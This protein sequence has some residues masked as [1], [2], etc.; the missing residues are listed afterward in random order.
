[1][2]KKGHPKN[3]EAI[4]VNLTS[5]STLDAFIDA[6]TKELLSG[7][8]MTEL[9]SEAEVT[10]LA[11]K[12]VLP[13]LPSLFPVMD[14][15][16]LA[17]H[18]LDDTQLDA[19]A[20]M[21]VVYNPDT[22]TYTREEVDTVEETNAIADN[23]K[24]IIESN[25]LTRTLSTHFNVLDV[26]NIGRVLFGDSEFGQ[27]WQNMLEAGRRR[28][29]PMKIAAHDFTQQA[30]DAL[31]GRTL[32][33]G[34]TSLE[35]V[36]RWTIDA[37]LNG[38]DTQVQI[39]PD[40]AMSIAGQYRTMMADYGHFDPEH[41]EKIAAGQ[42]PQMEV[43][44]V[45]LNDP[46]KQIVIRLNDAQLRDLSDMVFYQD[47]ATADLMDQFEQHTE[48]VFEPVSRMY[49]IMNSGQ[50]P[51]SNWYYPI[52]STAT[53]REL[54]QRKVQRFVDDASQL[55]ARQK[56]PKQI[57][58]YGFLSD[59]NRYHHDA[60]TYVQFAPLW[61]NIDKLLVRQEGNLVNMDMKKLADSLNKLRDAFATPDANRD[62]MKFSGWMAIDLGKLMQLATL[63]RFAFNIA[64]PIKQITGYFSAY[65]SGA[66][67]A[68]Y[69][70][71]ELPNYMKMIG[72]SYALVARGSRE[73]NYTGGSTSFDEGIA[74]LRSID[75]SA[76]QNMLWRVL[77]SGTPE[78][79]FD[80]FSSMKDVASGRAMIA[81]R[82]Q[83]FFEEYGLAATH[84]AD[85][86]VV[87]ALYNAA[88]R[89]V[90]ET[91]G[92][93]PYDEQQKMA[94]RMAKEALYYSNNTY[95]QTDRAGIQLNSNMFTQMLLLYKS[96]NMKI[97]NTLARRAIEYAQ[98]DKSDQN[99]V[100]EARRNLMG[101]M[102]LNAILAPVIT[103]LINYGVK[104]LRDLSKDDTNKNDKPEEVAWEVFF[105]TMAQV[106]Q[107]LPAELGE[108][109]TYIMSK[110]AN[111]DAPRELLDVSPFN[112]ISDF[113]AAGYDL[114]QA[115]VLNKYRNR[116]AF[117]KYRTRALQ[118]ALRA[119]ATV[120]GTPMEIVRQLNNLLG[121]WMTPKPKMTRFRMRRELTPAQRGYDFDLLK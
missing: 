34:M 76:A 53:E 113:I 69:L 3:R 22:D 14:E 74:E 117:E 6:R 12:A 26:A 97:Y 56:A 115:E 72:E 91:N 109:G 65:G 77:G 24:R 44:T 7:Q 94:A 102:A 30:Y 104:G 33:R 63:S 43:M 103:T 83:A 88:K 45:D 29:S 48:Q 120:T 100:A 121:N 17:A 13:P 54:N 4:A 23:I 81:G 89:Q 92:S 64:I 86:A 114:F 96:H 60:E 46:S 116:V 68:K 84:R 47:Q 16:T 93:L 41:K 57:R 18:Q 118:Q 105:S 62:A 52:S 71:Q 25:A 70:T 5:E 8:T 73:G 10:R 32:Y 108:I 98:A 21:D 112:V 58:A 79:Q 59:I 35:S 49:T 99:A 40:I 90:A 20:P 75:D 111:P 55:R 61:Q 119:T 11:K 9:A 27:K 38:T 107:V 106:A 36:D 1:M 67:D 2:G 85:V 37:E 50:L 15:A 66:I 87:M 51:K 82:L 19:L 28:I 80:D 110:I 95:D 31:T 39:T 78:V 42:E 101:N